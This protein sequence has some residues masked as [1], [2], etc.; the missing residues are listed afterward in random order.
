MKHSALERLDLALMVDQLMPWPAGRLARD[1]GHNNAELLQRT[2]VGDEAPDSRYWTSYD[3]FVLEREARAVRRDYLF[4][5]A[6]RSW[7]QLAAWVARSS[8]GFAARRNAHS[9]GA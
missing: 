2:Q 5:L 6:A 8:L 1:R 4:R 3:Y 7:A 9:S